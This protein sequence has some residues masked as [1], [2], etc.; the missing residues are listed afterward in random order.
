MR[1]ADKDLNVFYPTSKRI[2]ILKECNHALE[3]KDRLDAQ[4]KIWSLKE[5]NINNKI[6]QDELLFLWEGRI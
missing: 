1:L 5:K 3:I 6:M 4:I 2:K